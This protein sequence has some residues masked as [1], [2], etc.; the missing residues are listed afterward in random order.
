MVF[1]DPDTI[2]LAS[3]QK[4]PLENIERTD[5]KNRHQTKTEDKA[6]MKASSCRQVE[7]QTLLEGMQLWLTGGQGSHYGAA[8]AEFT[9]SLSSGA[10]GIPPVKC[11]QV[12]L[13]IERVLVEALFYKTT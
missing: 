2:A 11:W 10:Y 8:L 6:T 5:I 7:I 3:L 13:F 12:L 9:G 1:I 4:R